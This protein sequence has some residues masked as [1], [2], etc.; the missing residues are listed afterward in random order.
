M[1]A[2]DEACLRYVVKVCLLNPQG[3][4]T[5]CVSR[6]IFGLERMKALRAVV[7]L[8]KTC[9]TDIHLPVFSAMSYGPGLSG[10]T[11]ATSGCA[12]LL[13]G[14]CKEINGDDVE[15]WFRDGWKHASHSIV[16]LNV[17]FSTTFIN[18]NSTHERLEFQRLLRAMLIHFDP[19]RGSKI[20][21]LAM[22]NPATSVVR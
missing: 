17:C 18:L 14:F 8:E 13:S 3:R 4:L 9:K 19:P 1:C 2:M 20:A 12:T 21:L 16:F 15:R 22:D 11:P 5:Y 10:P 6:Y 7:K